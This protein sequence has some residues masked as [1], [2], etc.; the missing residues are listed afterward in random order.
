MVK[1]GCIF[2]CAS[3]LPAVWVLK[4][5]QSV[6]L[7][8]FVQLAAAWSAT[9]MA[10]ALVAV[11]VLVPALFPLKEPVLAPPT[12]PLGAVYVNAG[13]VMVCDRLGVVASIVFV[14]PCDGTVWP[15]SGI[16]AESRTCVS[17]PPTPPSK[18]V[19]DVPMATRPERSGRLNVVVPSP[20]P[21]V[22]PISS[23]SVEYVVRDTAEPSHSRNPLGAVL[24][25]YM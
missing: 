12:V 8:V 2:E 25:A 4:A 23:N 11:L 19:E 13:W 6:T 17:S 18:W 3:S 15:C 22:V 20:V 16:S 7:P 5:L 1:N 24:P 21:Y 9:A 10:V 14:W